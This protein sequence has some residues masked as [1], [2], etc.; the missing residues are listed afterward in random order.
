MPFSTSPRTASGSPSQFRTFIAPSRSFHF[1]IIFIFAVHDELSVSGIA[2][3]G[4]SPCFFTMLTNMFHWPPSPIG[5]WSKNAT[6]RSS[7]G[8][9]AVSMIC[10]RNQLARSNLSQNIAQFWLNS[11]DLTFIFS[12][13]GTRSMLRAAKSQ[14]RPDFFWFVTFQSSRCV[15]KVKSVDCTTSRTSAMSSMVFIVTAFWAIF[16]DVSFSKASRN[17]WIVSVVTGV[18]RL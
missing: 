2:V 6:V 9:S 14:H 5:S 17:V 4:T 10:C 8:L 3:L 11:N 18:C 15:E 13:A 1:K 7:T 16:A 12:I